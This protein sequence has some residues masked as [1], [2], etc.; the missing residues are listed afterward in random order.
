MTSIKKFQP[1]Q[2]LSLQ[3]VILAVSSVYSAIVTALIML[4]AARNSNPEVFGEVAVSIAAAVTLIGLADFGTNQLWLRNLTNGTLQINDFRSRLTWKILFVTISAC[5][6]IL[7]SLC[8][9]KLHL[10]ILITVAIGYFSFL[11]LNFQ[12]SLRAIGRSDIVAYLIVIER[13]ISLLG[14]VILI[15]IG[16][17]AST[18]LWLAM[19]LSSIIATI[20][21]AVV[22][23]KSA[24]FIPSWQNYSNPWSGSLS[25]GLTGFASSLN[26]L[27]LSLISSVL[28]NYAAGVYGAVGRWVQPL[29]IIVSSFAASSGPF[30]ANAQNIHSAFAVIKK[31]LWIPLTSIAGSIALFIFTPQIVDL[32]LGPAYAESVSVLRLLAI[33]SIPGFFNQIVLILLQFA[34]HEKSVALILLPMAFLQILMILFLSSIFGIQGAAFSYVFIQVLQGCFFGMLLFKIFSKRL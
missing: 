15:F 2:G 25:F 20:I 26:G 21:A 10:Q 3:T 31:S 8:H 34:G 12:I 17:T 6:L 13:T 32:L 29:Y 14:M 4:I 23:P 33:G 11:N 27:E 9:V 7:I 18:A 28:G 30:I 1:R 5:V 22:T 16:L 24:R 19:V